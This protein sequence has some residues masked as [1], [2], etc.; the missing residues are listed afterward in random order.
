M[1]ILLDV[2]VEGAAAYVDIQQIK[3][4]YEDISQNLMR[5]MAGNKGQETIVSSYSANIG[6]YIETVAEDWGAHTWGNFTSMVASDVSLS[7]Q[8]GTVIILST[9]FQLISFMILEIQQRLMEAA[10]EIFIESLE[11]GRRVGGNARRGTSAGG[12][13]VNRVRA[14][15][16]SFYNRHAGGA[17]W[18]YL[19]GGIP[20]NWRHANFGDPALRNIRNKRDF[21]RRLDAPGLPGLQARFAAGATDMQLA[22]FLD[23]TNRVSI[24]RSVVIPGG[25]KAGQRMTM[26]PSQWRWE[27]FGWGGPTNMW[28]SDPGGH[29]FESAQRYWNQQIDAGERTYKNRKLYD[30]FGNYRPEMEGYNPYTMQRQQQAG[31]FPGA[32]TWEGQSVPYGL[33]SR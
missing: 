20:S 3:D 28:I 27:A 23:T 15:A 11:G 22:L 7:A 31:Q 19:P 18:G 33:V 26:I 32:K 29:L 12:R 9:T 2:V 25:P 21:Y 5:D 6:G 10:K 13:G 16:N 17:S 1:S 14:Q 4:E 24:P 8:D 30:Q